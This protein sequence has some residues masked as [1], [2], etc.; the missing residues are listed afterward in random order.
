[1]VF[2]KFD[3]RPHWGQINRVVD[4]MWFKEMFPE[5]KK[6]IDSYQKFNKGHFDNDFTEQ[7]SLRKL[8]NDTNT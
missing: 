2:E 3:G 8:I 6:F 5:W 4:K 1:M 7:L